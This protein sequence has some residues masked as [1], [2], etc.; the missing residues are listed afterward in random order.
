MKV[1]QFGLL[2]K[3]RVKLHKTNEFHK[4]CETSPSLSQGLHITFRFHDSVFVKK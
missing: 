4:N 1:K 3:V 2:T